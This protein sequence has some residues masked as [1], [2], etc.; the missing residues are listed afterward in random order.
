VSTGLLD[1][2]GMH[3]SKIATTDNRVNVTRQGNLL[4]ELIWSIFM[5]TSFCGVVPTHQILYSLRNNLSYKCLY[6]ADGC[7]TAVQLPSH[8]QLVTREQL[9]LRVCCSLT[10]CQT[11]F[12]I[13]QV[14]ICL[15]DQ[16]KIW[17]H[18]SSRYISDVIKECL[19]VWTPGDVTT[20]MP[21]RDGLR[22]SFVFEPTIQQDDLMSWSWG[23][24]SGVSLLFLWL[25]QY[26]M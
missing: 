22:C 18:S 6:D 2:I 11:V 25:V 23:S 1:S 16:C 9:C 4:Q 3:I 13:S 20:T 5:S 26:N 17:R 21:W 19:R 24:G 10:C 8:L 15:P 14:A 12:A 7:F